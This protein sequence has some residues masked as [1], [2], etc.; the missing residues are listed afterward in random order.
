V[1]HRWDSHRSVRR[2]VHSL[3]AVI[4]WPVMAIVWIFS[5]AVSQDNSSKFIYFDF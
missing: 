1:T 5:L 4:L 2:C 3:P